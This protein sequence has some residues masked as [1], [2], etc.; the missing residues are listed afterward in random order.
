MQSWLR[1]WSLHRSL[2]ALTLACVATATDESAAAEPPPAQPEPSQT[3]P[4]TG[5]LRE[6]AQ[7]VILLLR[8]S[9]DEETIA[10]LRFELE[11]GGFHILEL[12]ADPDVAA[13]SL[14]AVAQGKQAAAAVR[15]D[16]TRG[17]A[18][19]WVRDHRGSIEE[20]F[21]AE[22]DASRHHVLALR[23]AETL[24]ARGLLLPPSPSPPPAEPK[25]QPQP[26]PLADARASGPGRASRDTRELSRASRFSLELGPGLL[27]S[28]GGLEPLAAIE[29]GMRLEYE[30]RWSV[31]AFG[32]IP[33]S[34]QSVEA[35]EG[36]AVTSSSLAAG[37]FEIEWLD[38]RF[39][40]VRSGLGAGLTITTMSGRG[41]SG[42]RGED[43]TVLA[44]SPLASTSVHM[45][46]GP[47]LRLRTGVAG[48]Y[49][50]P[51][52]KVAFGT[53]EVVSWGRPFVLSSLV[54]E[55]SPL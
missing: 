19:L 45:D 18:E 6:P 32:T 34:R 33:I 5:H 51:E 16:A 14:S 42:F 54:L 29:L 49:T 30:R 47:R 24:R 9:G 39:G 38:W 7:R 4:P 21:T 12:R 2:L 31:Y 11:D 55:V 3:S 26:Q 17:R 22:A 53:R 15:V 44:F 52:V 50:V 28:P 1:V 43:D 23:V 25:P 48:G 27:V 37:L 35:A 46:L 8:T 40:G 41:A 36:E 10:R 20:T 13:Q